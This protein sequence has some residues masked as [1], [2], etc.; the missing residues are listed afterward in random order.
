MLEL[1]PVVLDTN[2][3]EAA[4]RSRRGASFAL[5][6]QIGMGRFE[7]A[8]S[9]PLFL[10]YEGVLMR[11][12]SVMDRD[13]V[14]VTNLLDYLCAVAKLHAIFYLWR[15]LLADANDEMVL[16]LAVAAGCDAIVTHNR[17][18]LLPASQFGVRVLSPGEF[19]GEI[20]GI[21]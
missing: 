19:L 21:R 3:L 9:V 7:I 15:P 20:G 12:A 1:P 18:H 6:S 13:P 10:A 17:R 11:Q 5:V 4:M 2:V 14:M 8:L 16:E